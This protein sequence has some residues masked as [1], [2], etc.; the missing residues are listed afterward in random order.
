MRKLAWLCQAAMIVG[1]A[2]F[3]P[4][5]QDQ[6]VFSLAAA[7]FTQA[8]SDA[9]RTTSADS[10]A[11]PPNREAI[12]R[13]MLEAVNTE[14]DR[15]LLPPLSTDE[16]LSHLADF[17]ACRL[18]EDGFFSH[19][20]PVD[21]TTIDARA[22]TFGYAFLKIGENL[23]AGQG[24]VSAAMRDW[25]ASP[26]HRANILDPAYTEIGL[27]VKLGGDCG[28]YWVQE[29]GRPLV[30]PA[31]S[32]TTRHADPEPSPSPMPSPSSSPATRD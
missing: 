14:R 32:A 6:D 26:E 25:M 2:A 11:D 15:R 24:T 10:C 30:P 20:D 16:T 18:V 9:A 5:C 8:K 1:L 21:N 29:F 7:S 4:A 28:I 17:Y 19:E 31:D 13:E 3:S 22:A 23:A 12:L 27:A